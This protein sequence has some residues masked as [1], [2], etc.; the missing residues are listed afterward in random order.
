MLQ[1]L[2]PSRIIC[3]GFHLTHLL[4]PDLWEEIPSASELVLTEICTL[5]RVLPTGGDAADAVSQEV[6]VVLALFLAATEGLW[7]TE[8]SDVT[9]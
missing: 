7:E 1:S 8:R 2:E 5:L 4:S 6:V 3:P 9:G